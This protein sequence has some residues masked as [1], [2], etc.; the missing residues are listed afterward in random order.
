MERKKNNDFYI[1]FKKESMENNSTSIIQFSM[2][3]STKIFSKYEQKMI[4]FNCVKKITFGLY[5]QPDDLQALLVQFHLIRVWFQH[6]ETHNHQAT[7]NNST[8][9]N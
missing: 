6:F 1:L 5:N 9:Y 7:V 2:H 4:C 3:T 8:V